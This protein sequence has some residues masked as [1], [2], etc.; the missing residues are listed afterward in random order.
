MAPALQPA[1]AGAR[2]SYERHRPEETT[3]YRVVQE[4]LETF[5]LPSTRA[6]YQPAILPSCEPF[7]ALKKRK[8]SDRFCVLVFALGPCHA[9]VASS[10]T[11][12]NPM[13]FALR[14]R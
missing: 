11:S 7:Q 8:L 1:Q 10:A 4:E 3:L 14:L 12:R 9:P 13:T 2:F 6:A 5:D